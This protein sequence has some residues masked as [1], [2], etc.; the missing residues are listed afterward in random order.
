MPLAALS[1]KAALGPS[2]LDGPAP[3]KVEV[4]TVL[5]DGEDR[6][7]AAN[8]AY[9]E[10]MDGTLK[11]RL[12]QRTEGRVGGKGVAKVCEFGRH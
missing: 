12:R 3:H 8:V 2:E 9:V 10:R 4:L 5:S 1:E 6:L 7:L 11:S